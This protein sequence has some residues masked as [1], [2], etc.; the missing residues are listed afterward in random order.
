MSPR[1]L[2]KLKTSIT[3]NSTLRERA[4]RCFQSISNHF[5]VE[6][7][8]TDRLLT[9]H[10]DVRKEDALLYGSAKK[11]LFQSISSI[12]SGEVK[13]RAKKPYNTKE[14]VRTTAVSSRFKLEP[15]AKVLYK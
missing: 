2:S 10:Q 3:L 12:T 14:L 13:K 7:P 1:C 5:E 4:L 6:S 11:E 9:R 15:V 8:S